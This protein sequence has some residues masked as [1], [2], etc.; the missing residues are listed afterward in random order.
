MAASLFKSIELQAAIFYF[1]LLVANIGHFQVHS[2]SGPV[3]CNNV[4]RK[5]N[6]S[7]FLKVLSEHLGVQYFCYSATED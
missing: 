2:V 4:A 1:A 3:K 6:Y 5:E 7:H